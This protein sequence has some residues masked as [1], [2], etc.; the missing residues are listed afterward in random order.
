M[1]EQDAMGINSQ[2]KRRP[3]IKKRRHG[4]RPIPVITQERLAEEEAARPFA[5]RHKKI[6]REIERDVKRGAMIEPGDLSWPPKKG[7]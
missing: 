2:K 4:D 6:L 3:T 5:K 7:D 1:P